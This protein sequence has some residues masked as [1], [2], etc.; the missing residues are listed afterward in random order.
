MNPK[1]AIPPMRTVTRQGAKK[2]HL[3][4]YHGD[5]GY[6]TLCGQAIRWP[7]QSRVFNAEQIGCTECLKEAVLR[8]LEKDY[9]MVRA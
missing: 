3:L 8:K 4:D 1:N 7:V 6:V 5:D 2:R 9:G